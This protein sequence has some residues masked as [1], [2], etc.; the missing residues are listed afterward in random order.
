M[1]RCER[2]DAETQ[3]NDA[4]IVNLPETRFFL[5]GMG[6]RPKLLY[7]AGQ[8]LDVATHEPVARWPVRAERI[9]PEEYRVEL[10]GRDGDVAIFEDEAGV[11]VE[12]GG[13]LAPI[14]QSPP[15]RLPRFETFRRRKLLRVLHHEMLV[16][17]VAGRPSPN[18][19]A[20]TKPWYRDAAMVAMALKLTGNETLLAD[21]IGSLRDPF[22][23]NNG[24]ACEPDNLGQA[25]YLI[26]LTHSPAHPLVEEILAAAER[27]RRGDHIA[28]MTDGREHPAYQTKWLKFGLAALKLD[29]FWQIPAEPD[30]YSSLFWMAYRDEHVPAGRFN[31]RQRERYP[32]LAWAEAH[33]HNAPPP[34]ELANPGYPLTWE[35]HASQADYAAA[36]WV[37]GDFASRQICMP[38]AWHAA[39]M[40]LYLS[41]E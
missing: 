7:R 35:S 10:A 20:Y 4:G 33:F 29:D 28:G 8:L 2:G 22:D 13:R 5:F 3:R 39:E 16:N 34:M 9:V 1:R 31:S 11:W 37:S 21:W 14:S 36:A 23:R 6:N 41:E 40:F 38:H 17:I 18:L 12:Q 27:F 25:L 30:S 15:I 32:Y 24:G 26:S 19:F